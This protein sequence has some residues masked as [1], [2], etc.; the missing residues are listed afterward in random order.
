MARRG[1]RPTP[2]SAGPSRTR[3]SPLTWAALGGREERDRRTP[4]PGRGAS[5]SRVL[6]ARGEPGTKP[7]YRCARLLPA[8]Q[9]GPA[10]PREPGMRAPRPRLCRAA[11]GTR[12]L[13]APQPAGL[14]ELSSVRPPQGPESTS[15]RSRARAPLGSRGGCPGPTP[16]VLPLPPPPSEGRGAQVLPG[17]EVK[18]VSKGCRASAAAPGA[19][20]AGPE[21][22]AGLRGRVDLRKGSGGAPGA[23]SPRMDESLR[24]GRELRFGL[25]APRRRRRRRRPLAPGSRLL[26]VLRRH[27]LGAPGWGVAQPRPGAGSAL[28]GPRDV[29][30]KEERRRRAP[31]EGAPAPRSG[32]PAP[33]PGLSSQV[34]VLIVLFLAQGNH[35]KKTVILHEMEMSSKSHVNPKLELR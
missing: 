31:A 25:P 13:T 12:A 15:A 3:P 8:S 26:L 9:T 1:A 24:P 33:R 16:S 17:G 10:R 14:G 6:T 7:R 19:P 2:G 29:E 32:A 27:L 30:G 23:E 21:Q 35:L 11:S 5:G 34:R 28:S 20:R 22:S 4:S 18:V